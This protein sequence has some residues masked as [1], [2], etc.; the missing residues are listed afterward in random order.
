[1][2]FEACGSL[3]YCSCE[4]DRQ[5]LHLFQQISRVDVF[6]V[7]YRVHMFSPLFTWIPLFGFSKL[8][9]S[10]NAPKAMQRKYM[11]FSQIMWNLFKSKHFFNVI[12]LIPLV[13]LNLFCEDHMPQASLLA[14]HEVNNHSFWQIHKYNSNKARIITFLKKCILLNGLCEIHKIACPKN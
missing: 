10:W 6:Y 4:A 12:F 9:I 1:M 3:I 8:N 7:M 14:D 2:K 5:K 11:A 13:I